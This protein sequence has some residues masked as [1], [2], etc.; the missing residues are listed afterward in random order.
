MSTCTGHSVL[1]ALQL[2]QRS[3]A[4]WTASLW[5]PSSRRRRPASPTAGGRGRGWSAA[6]RRWRDS[7]GTSRRRSSCGTRPRPRSARWRAPASRH[8]WQTRSAFRTLVAMSVSGRA[9]DRHVAEVFQ[10]IVD[11]HRIDQLAGIHAVVGI[12]ERLELAKGLHQFRPEHLGQQRGAR[13]AVAVLAAERSA[14]AEH[15]IG[16]AVEEFAEIRAGPSRCG[17]RS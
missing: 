2:R 15:Q 11:A 12:P 6:P 4:S 3:S 1:Q 16:G 17:S 10:R 8:R 7:W 5:K 14:K 13:L 9:V